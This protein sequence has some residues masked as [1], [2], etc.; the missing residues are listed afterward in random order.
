[1]KAVSYLPGK[2]KVIATREKYL[3][4]DKDSKQVNVVISTIHAHSDGRYS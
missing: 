2:V 1:M 3:V 4:Y